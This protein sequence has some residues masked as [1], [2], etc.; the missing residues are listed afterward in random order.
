MLSSV[1]FHLVGIE[2]ELCVCRRLFSRWLFS[3]TEYAERSRS[4]DAS[5]GLAPCFCTVRSTFREYC[6][7]DIRMQDTFGVSFFV[8]IFQK[9]H[10][11]QIPRRQTERLCFRG[12]IASFLK[13]PDRK[14]VFT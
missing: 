2:K 11:G 8:P 4:A 1:V 9:R 5:S 6:R 10:G 12:I 3:K 13:Q 14:E 7:V